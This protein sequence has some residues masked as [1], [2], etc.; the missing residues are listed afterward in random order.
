MQLSDDTRS[1]RDGLAPLAAS[2]SISRLLCSDLGLPGGPSA[3][4]SGLEGRAR[5]EPSPSLHGG[6]NP[7]SDVLP[8]KRCPQGA[9]HHACTQVL[10]RPVY[11][12][13][14]IL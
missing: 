10:N 8:T 14:G 5:T 7:G 9:Q 6:D 11:A 12:E 3:L 13:C 1:E 4:C 2:S